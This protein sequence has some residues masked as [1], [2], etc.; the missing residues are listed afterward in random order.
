M[1]SELTTE[2]IIFVTLA[3]G[4]VGTLVAFC[5]IKVLRGETDLEKAAEKKKKMK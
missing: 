3:W 1:F 2:G 4:T 5:L